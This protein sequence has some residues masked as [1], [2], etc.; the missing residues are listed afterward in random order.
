MAKKKQPTETHEPPELDG[1]FARTGGKV[2]D[3]MEAL[4]ASLRQQKE[5]EAKTAS[6]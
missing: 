3:L 5:L 4:K 6:E 2:I 1:G